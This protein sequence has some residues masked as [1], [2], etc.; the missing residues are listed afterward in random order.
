[1]TDLGADPAGA[2]CASVTVPPGT[3]LSPGA[4]GTFV[5]AFTNNETTDAVDVGVRLHGLPEGWKT[6]VAEK[7]GNLLGTVKP[8]DSARTAWLLT[9][10]ADAAG[11]T[12]RTPATA[13]AA[14]P[15]MCWGLT[16]VG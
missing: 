10:P 4:P 9:P 2:A 15:L 1:M 12:P 5:T 14:Q 13:H 8:G 7:D 11:T 6:E 16:R 3:E